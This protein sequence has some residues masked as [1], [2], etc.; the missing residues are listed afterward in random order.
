MKRINIY[1]IM[2]LFAFSFIANDIFSQRTGNRNFRGQRG[3]FWTQLDENQKQELQAKIKELRDAGASREEVQQAINSLLE[4]YGIQLPEDSRKRGRFARSGRGLLTGLIKGLDE[5]QKQAIQEKHKELREAGKTPEEVHVEIGI[6]LQSFG[7]ELPGNWDELQGK[8]RR[9]RE[10]RGGFNSE[11]SEEQKQAIQTKMKELNDQ[12]ASR[13]EIHEAITEMLTGYG[14]DIPDDFKRGA[15]FGS[16][17]RGPHLSVFK[18][19]TDDQKK[20]IQE[21]TKEMHEQNAKPEEIHAAVGEMLQSFG[22]ELPENWDEMQGKGGRGRGIRGKFWK[23]L[24]E[25]QKEELH[26]MI[27]SLK[28]NGA[29]GKEI[30]EAVNAKLKEFGIE[31]PQRRR[32]NR[33]NREDAGFDEQF[34]NLKGLQARNYPNPFNPETNIVY[35]LQNPEKVLVR[36]YNANGQLVRTL[37]NADQSAGTHT[38]LWNGQDDSGLMATSG[39]YFYRIDAGANSITQGMILMK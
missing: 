1:A 28:E 2:L 27:K 10:I 14:I 18:D 13:E 37:L 38:V 35:T 26:E 9:G 24:N 21:K 6:L 23:Q 39:M 31:P 22:V 4:S 29:T 7:V 17:G 15:R 12:D 5:S 11:L 30:R 34:D 20:A 8:G 36:I 32:G 3:G 16:R 25:T 19:L 33:Q